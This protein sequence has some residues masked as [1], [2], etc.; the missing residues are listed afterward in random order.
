MLVNSDLPKGCFVCTSTSEV[1]G[2][3]LP[4]SSAKEVKEINKQ[5]FSFFN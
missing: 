5:T 2:S 4:E 3:R 1:A